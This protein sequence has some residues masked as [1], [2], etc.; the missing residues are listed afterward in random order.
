[1]R[2]VR[3][4]IR[5]EDRKYTGTCTRCKSVIESVEKELN[6]EFDAR[7]GSWFGRAACPVCLAGMVFYPTPLETNTQ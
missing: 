2:V 5:P 6:A 1:M 7:E 3:Q 4:G